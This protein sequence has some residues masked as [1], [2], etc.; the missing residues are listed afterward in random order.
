MQAQAE[1]QDVR[2][3]V[4]KCDYTVLVAEPG[5]FKAVVRAK[6]EDE[7]IEKAWDKV[8]EFTGR[9]PDTVDEGEAVITSSRD[10]SVR[11][12]L[13]DLTL[14]LFPDVSRGTK[15]DANVEP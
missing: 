2:E 7:A 10:I 8:Y 6:N 5:T 13:D 4:I 12:A 3:Y 1:E 14:D 11:G 9:D 15:G